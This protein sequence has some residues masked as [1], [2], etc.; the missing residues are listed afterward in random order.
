MFRRR[1]DVGVGGVMVV[2]SGPRL[3]G[4]TFGQLSRRADLDHV[5]SQVGAL[6]RGDQPTTRVELPTAQPVTS[7]GGERMVVVVPCLAESEWCEPGEVARLIASRER[8]PAEEVAQRVDTERHVM[9]EKHA[10]RP[11]PQQSRES[12][13]Y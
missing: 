7:G 1:F 12:P 3:N 5:P 8:S 13:H 4:F 2:I 6:E 9:Q 11:S 10:H